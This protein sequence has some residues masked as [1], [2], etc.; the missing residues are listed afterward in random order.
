MSLK[1]PY[2]LGVSV[3]AAALLFATVPSALLRATTDDAPGGFVE[4]MSATTVRPKITGAQTS[5][6][7]SRG[8]FTFPAPYNTQGIRLTNASDCSGGSDCVTPVGYSYWRNMNNSA[9]SDQLLIFL[10][11]DR[12][13]GGGGPT[14][15]SYNKLTGA[16]TNRGP[17]FDSNSPF[18]W[19]NGEGWYF[20]GTQP[21]KLYV[22]VSGSSQLYRYDVESHALDL[23]FDASGNF[24]GGKYIWQIHSSMDDRVH[25]FT[26]R[27]SSTYANLGC[28]AYREDTHQYSYFAAR[29]SFDE[30]QIDKSGRYLV[31]KENVDG[32]NGEDNVIEDLQTGGEQI[33]L[34]QNGAGG[35]SDAG[36]G[37][38][39]AEDNF[40]AQPGAVR[41]WNLGANLSDPSQGTLVFHATDWGFGANHVSHGN[42]VAASSGS[43]YV[44][45]SE[46]SRQDMPRAN[47]VLCYPLSGG[48]NAVVVAPVMTDLNAAGGGDDYMKEPKGNLDPTGQYF[49]WTSNLGSSR[50]DAFVVRV[51]TSLLPASTTPP[52]PPPPAPTGDTTPP[53]V[54]ISAPAANATVS[55]ETVVTA[56]ASDNTG[57]AGVQFYLDG[58]TLGPEITS[59]PYGVA[60]STSATPNGTHTITA[61]ARDAA[62]NTATSGG[63]TVNVQN[64]TTTDPGPAGSNNPKALAVVWT[65]L[66][67]ASVT[68]STLKKSGGCSGCP[69][70]GALSQQQI[71]S[72]DGYLEFTATD[73]APLR[74]IGLGARNTGT[75]GGEI[76][77]A[78]R[79]QSGVL[80]VREGGAYRTE[81]SFK[82]G[83]VIRIAVTGGRLTYSK[84]G[85]VFYTSSMSATYPLVADTAFYDLNASISNA[86]MAGTSTSTSKA[87]LKLSR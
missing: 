77:F 60:W 74:F 40:Y 3:F 11:L 52:P 81:T 4:S 46:V 36:F 44:C 17:M 13:K 21:T 75:T 56:N 49:V 57:V 71:S 53:T 19:G 15:F 8:V 20:S 85:T 10:S 62:G 58:V 73:A 72:G 37:Y 82:K 30:C 78:V 76:Q 27:D 32:A 86:V 79:L 68:G 23:V 84:N 83:D 54:S 6:L 12:T 18:S 33:L 28:G 47:E 26:L 22:N 16:T 1:S 2:G 25:S 31:I 65:S 55:G 34:D 67:H 24:G 9:G 64:T 38:M 66:V 48:N 70:S 69:D 42:A 35:H 45:S 50:M 61:R 80:E 41:V 59:T 5:F 7:P 87:A 29:G 43:Q 14:L 51:P 63:V 39:V